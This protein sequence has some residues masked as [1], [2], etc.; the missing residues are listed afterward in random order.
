MPRFL[1][2]RPCN[3]WTMYT[4]SVLRSR[5]L[6]HPLISI[7]V[8]APLSTTS[9]LLAKDPSS[10]PGWEGRGPESHAVN[11]SQLDPQSQGAQQGIKDHEDGKE[12]GQA[13]SRKDEG[14]ANKKAKKEHPK[15][16]EPVI[17]MNDERGEFS[18]SLVIAIVSH[19]ESVRTA[20]SI[21]PP[22]DFE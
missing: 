10:T 15:A 6:C 7:S 18:L 3:P 17:G 8:R 4:S 14:N 5:G 11:R 9:L 22:T 12:G 1:A 19:P 20:W 21:H 13:I 2:P 16:P